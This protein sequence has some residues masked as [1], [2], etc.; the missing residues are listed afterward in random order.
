MI[1]SF[2]NSLSRKERIKNNLA[3]KFLISTDIWIFVNLFM[4]LLISIPYINFFTHGTH[5]TVAHSMGTTI[6][7]NTSIL[8]SSMMFLPLK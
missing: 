2:K 3:Y 4:A 7:I 5:I 6:G 8:L 1:V